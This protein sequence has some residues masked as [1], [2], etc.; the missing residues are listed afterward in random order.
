MVMA[1]MLL[2]GACTS[3]APRSPVFTPSVFVSDQTP[4]SFVPPPD[5][6]VVTVR[7]KPDADLITGVLRTYVA[8]VGYDFDFGSPGP[9]SGAGASRVLGRST[10]VVIVQYLWSP[11][12]EAIGWTASSSTTEVRPP[13]EWHDDAQNPGWMFRERRVCAGDGCISALEWHGPEASDEAV[14]LGQGMTE[15]IELAANWTDG[16]AS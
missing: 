12:E 10:V 11:P 15:S 4:W 2:V 14:A 3:D 7:S 5:W 1:V 16:V 8:S 6:H 13:T 9:N